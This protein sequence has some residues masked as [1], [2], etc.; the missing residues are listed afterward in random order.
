MAWTFKFG[1]EI[2]TAP[3]PHAVNVIDQ[4]FLA[5]AICV[6]RAKRTQGFKK[7]N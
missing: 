1:G 7:N 5:A 2:I 3:H 6:F 4:Q